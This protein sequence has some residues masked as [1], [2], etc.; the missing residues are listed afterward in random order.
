[1]FSLYF[2]FSLFKKVVDIPEFRCKISNYPQNKS[3]TSVFFPNY[4]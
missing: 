2:L 1:M 3:M 4:P